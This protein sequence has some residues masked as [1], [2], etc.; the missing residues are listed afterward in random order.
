LIPFEGSGAGLVVMALLVASFLYALVATVMAVF[1]RAIPGGPDWS[2]FLVPS[3]CLVGLGIAGYLTFVEARQATAI[4]GPVGDCNAV[5]SSPYAKLFGVLPVGILGLLGYLAILTA[6]VIGR[7]GKGGLSD[8]ASV[9]MFGF[10]LFGVLFSIYLTYLELAIILAICM[11]CL[12]S[13]VLMTVLLFL[14]T[15]AALTRLVFQDG[16]AL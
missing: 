12:T 4:C 1:G 15:R 3:L 16:A 5:Q 11:W 13:A 8:L 14:T 6:W 9:A 10:S 7:F 2:G